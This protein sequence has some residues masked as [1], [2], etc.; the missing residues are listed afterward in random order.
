MQ[1]L[2]LL[3]PEIAAAVTVI[4]GMFCLFHASGD[5]V[6]RS[7]GVQKERF[8]GQNCRK[9]KHWRHWGTFK[10]NVMLQGTKLRFSMYNR[11]IEMSNCG[12]G[13]GPY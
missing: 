6:L 10:W 4:A 12:T 13:T 7:S 1:R 9:N 2:S 5:D 3:Y 11:P 8:N